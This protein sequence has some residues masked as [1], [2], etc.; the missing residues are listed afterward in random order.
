M[1]INRQVYCSLFRKLSGR[2]ATYTNQDEYDEV[3]YFLSKSKFKNSDCRKD[4]KTEDT[5]QI[6]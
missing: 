6:G 4:G 1:Q 2:L 5:Y 3:I